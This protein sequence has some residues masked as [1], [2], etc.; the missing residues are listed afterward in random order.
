MSAYK[1]VWKGT[2]GLHSPLNLD[3]ERIVYAPGN[4]RQRRRVVRQQKALGYEVRVWVT[5]LVGLG[6]W[7]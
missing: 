4:A 1:R 3:I 7:V 2:L 5:P 6:R